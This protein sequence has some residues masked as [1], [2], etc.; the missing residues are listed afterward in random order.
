MYIIL[1]KAFII[2]IRMFLNMAGS[3]ECQVRYQK[4]TANK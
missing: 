1:Q 3:V 2:N 4:D